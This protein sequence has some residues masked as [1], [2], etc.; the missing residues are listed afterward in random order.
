MSH[1]EAKAGAAKLLP[2]CIEQDNLV[3]QDIVVDRIADALVAASQQAVLD[4][5]LRTCEKCGIK[6][7]RANGG[8]CRC[9]V[10]DLLRRSK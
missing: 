10:E 9:G 4:L 6:Y 8:A 7:D 2:M 3:F 1:D 5:G